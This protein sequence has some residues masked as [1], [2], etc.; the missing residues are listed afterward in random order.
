[1]QMVFFVHTGRIFATV[2]DTEFSIGKGGIFVVP[3]GM[4]PSPLRLSFLRGVLSFCKS[5]ARAF[6]LAPRQLFP[7]RRYATF[8]LDGP[9]ETG[10]HTP[11]STACLG[12][13]S[14]MAKSVTDRPFLFRTYRRAADPKPP[15]RR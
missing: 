6:R 9:G 13:R 7:T 10:H 12:T 11:T 8:P 15:Q 1:M 3:R 5:L 14:A 4:F 2:A